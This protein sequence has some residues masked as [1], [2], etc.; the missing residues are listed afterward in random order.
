MM[1]EMND[2]A[3]TVGLILGRRNVAASDRIAEDLGAESAD[4]LNIV[5]TI[6]EKYGISISEADVATIRTV[7]E[8]RDL[9]GRTIAMSASGSGR[10]DAPGTP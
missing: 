2:I 10:S 1:V 4:V 8:L 6:E 7:A 9:V 3:K 5:A